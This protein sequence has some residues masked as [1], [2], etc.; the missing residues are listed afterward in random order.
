MEM[1]LEPRVRP[2]PYK[3]KAT[4]R[5][6]P[7]QKA[8]HVLDSDLRTHWSTATNTK[9]WI[10]LELDEACLLSQIRIYNK[11]VLEWEITVGLRYKPEA[12][13]KVRPRCEAPR[14]DMMYPMNY[15]PCRYVRI[16]CLR[17]N[18]IAIFSIQ[19]IGVPVPGLEPEFQPVV[20][21]LLPHIVSHKQ[22]ADDMHLQ[23]LQDIAKRLVVFLPYLE[24]D[25]TSFADAAESKIR[26]LAMLVGP[27]Y[28]VLRLVI[29]REATKMQLNPADLDASRNNQTSNPTVS[30][31]FVAQPRRSRSPSF[32][33]PA[34]G[35]IAFRYDAVFVVLRKAYNDTHLG[36]VCRRLSRILQSLME[37]KESFDESVPYGD[38]TLCSISE[39]I[40]KNEATS[41]VHL[42]DFSCLFGEVFRIVEIHYDAAYLN[43]LDTAAVEEGILHVLYAS[44]SQPTLC[45]KLADSNS[46][47]WSILPLVQALLPALRPLSSSSTDQ[48]DDS[49][50]Q[51]KHPSAQYALSQIVKMTSS[52]V[53]QPLIH[54]CAGY[55]SS[56]SPSHAKAACVLIDLCSGPLSPWISTIILKVDLTIELLEDLL[57]VIQGNRQ[58][59]TRSRAALKYVILAIS[60]H[61][62]D[63]LAEYKEVKHKLLFL[64]EML[65][66]FLDPAITAV[67]NTIAFGD[68][69]AVFLEKQERACAI[70]LNIIRKAVKKH[71][72]LPSLESEWRR[73]SIASSVLL[74]ILDPYMPLPPDVDICKS[75]TSKVD[76]ESFTAN[77][78]P[79]SIYFSN[80]VD[81]K[82]DTSEGNMFEE[83]NLLFVSAE[84]KQ[85]M[86]LSFANINSINS[87]DKISPESSHSTSEGKPLKERISAGIF[88]LDNVFS[89]D[90]HNTLADYLQLSNVHDCE[91]RALEFQRLALDLCSQHDSTLEGHNAGIDA[92]LLAAECYVNPFFIKSFRQNTKL[93]NQIDSIRSKLIQETDVLELDRKFPRKNDLAPVAHSEEK[94]D[95]TV[96]EILLQAAKLDGEYQKRTYAGEPYP[97]DDEE[98]NR[99]IEISLPDLEF[100]DAV[101][102]VRKNQALLSRFIIRQLQ[103]EEHSSLEIL[104]Q[105][106][107]FLLESATELYSHAENVIDIILHSA[108]NLNRQLMSLYHEMKAGNVQLDLEKLHG[109]RRRWVLLQ[110]L[111]LASSGDNEG[112]NSLGIRK[113]GVRFRSLVPPSSWI[114]KISYFS[115]CACPL[116]RLLGWMAVSRYAK[117]YLNE[118]LFLASDFS[119]LTLL[120]SIFADELVLIGKIVKQKVMA[121]KMEP[122][123]NRSFLQDKK[124]LEHSDPLDSEPSF[125]VLHPYLHFYFPSIIKQFGSFA[126]NILEAVGLQLKCLPSNAV[127]DVLCWFSEMCLW[128]YSG[129]PKGHSSVASA[130]DCL[131]ACTAVNAKGIVLY[132]LESIV[133]RHMEAI[134]P[135]MPRVAKILVSLCRA[136]YTDVAFLESV[137]SL[138]RPLISY[139]LR[140]VGDNE[141]LLTNVSLYQDFEL[142]SFEELFDIISCREESEDASRQKS[143]RLSL[144]IFILGSLFPDFSFSK[145]I[146]I[147]KSLL[148]W[149]DFTTSEPT[150]SFY[151]YLSAFLKVMDSCEAVLVQYLTSLGFDIPID[152]I[153]LSEESSSGQ[154]VVKSTEDLGSDKPDSGLSIREIDCL[155]ALDIKEFYVGIGKLISQLI[156]AIEVSW[157]LHYQLA[158]RLSFSIA[159]CELLSRCLYAI[160]ETSTYFNVQDVRANSKC[161]FGDLKSEYCTSALEGLVGVISTSQQN[162]CWLVSSA[163]LE[164]LL[165]LP[166]GISL[167]RVLSSICFVIKYCCLHA[168]R[169]SW[170]LQ[171]DKW[172]S[173]LLVRGVSCLENGETSLAD[174]FHT[175]LNHPEPE[176]RSIALGQLGRIAKLSSDFDTVTESCRVNQNSIESVIS[177]LVSKT[178]NIVVTLALSDTSVLLRTQAMALLSDYAPF[179]DRNHLQSFLVSSDTILQGM[180]KLNHTIE[181]GYLTQLSL[182][183]LANACLY[184]PAEDISLIPDSVW[185]NLES[186]GVSRAE[187]LLC[188]ALCRLRTDSVGAK[189]AISEALSSTSTEKPRDPDFESTRESILEVLSS[190]SS[191]K[192]YFD[193]FSRRI[194]G[195]SQ[196]LEEAE[197]EMELLQKEKVL[198]EIPEYPREDALQFSYIRD[199]KDDNKT[200]DRLRQ[201]KDNIRSLERSKLKEEI[202]ARRQKKL[203]IRHARQKYLE[204]ATSREMELLQELDRER[205]SETEREIGRQRQLEVERGKTRELQ[206]NVDMEREKQTQ[207]ELQRELEQVES[208][209]RSSRREISSTQNSRPRERYRERENARSG[210]QQEGSLRASSRDREAGTSQLVAHGPTTPT[211]VLAGS[212]SFS[213]HIP[214]ILQSRDRAADERGTTYEESVEGSRDSGDGSSI[215]DPELGSAF[216]GLVPRHGS[217]GSRSRQVVERREREGRREGK[218]ER[219]HS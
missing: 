97:D 143:I 215:G 57:S 188:Q 203:L 96:L 26:F 28:P 73:G 161:D 151:D 104:L 176:Q 118:R 61:M 167:G 138:L 192:S 191:V 8:S 133:A 140:K 109:V 202:I 22:D 214:T 41:N 164:Y 56:Y 19:L 208:G 162:Q 126:D 160:S 12:F 166:E 4:S 24:A 127:P 130:G 121:K 106:L 86:L 92:L 54:A 168:P 205:T 47:V 135:E 60:G 77:V 1:E 153:L 154:R 114:A 180:G 95:K 200:N 100:A 107:L 94:R 49:F 119:Q 134:V 32:I 40:A 157:K 69:S 6:S 156:P 93:I 196:E 113:N 37:P 183:L 141:R 169:I 190:L 52:S 68:H 89:A 184:S 198:E 62:D 207:R 194:D 76:E 204:E 125:Q 44:A 182:I 51:W 120:L 64:L 87:S 21:Y 115:N 67:K 218:W 213:G 193:Y 74:S 117:E 124:D 9:E 18:P 199:Y 122:F 10:L 78:P 75:S 101:T 11:S 210:Q 16:Y 197:I 99:F 152:R 88:R 179:T 146:E 50:C 148:G 216:D 128:P 170:R 58:S 14:R 48:V 174:L 158:L 137:L 103:R 112:M 172:L 178:W 13:V 82:M 173:L 211:I 181:E 132:V 46:D 187:K 20:N 150:S 80:D 23:L 39:E 35:S 171:T 131:K 83:S 110:K 185:R 81:G 5:E 72:V 2:L 219:K 189:S 15:T 201:I 129:N 90:Y 149:V 55:L 59:I 142:S 144:V 165:K 65:E 34:S 85:S 186:M 7:T 17:G 217:R 53:Y 71:P 84:L 98:N 195:E 25:L 175:M 111:V 79:S 38:S 147:L 45:S 36:I 159:K 105:S 163:M 212:R 3:V 70:A 33:Q 27:F 206:F 66:P 116:P 102:L 145:K 42:S 29:E 155:S 136:S 43:L 91:S 177:V 31:N 209:V 30:S 63:V 108:E 139:F 123:E